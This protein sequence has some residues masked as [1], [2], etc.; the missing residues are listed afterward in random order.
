MP[1]TTTSPNASMPMVLLSE[2]SAPN[3]TSTMATI[4]VSSLTATI[5]S[6][7]ATCMALPSTK[8]SPKTLVPKPTGCWLTTKAVSA[9]LSIT[10]AASS[11]SSPTTATAI[12]ST[13]PTPASPFAS[14]TPAA[15]GMA[16]PDSIT[17]VRDITM[18]ES[19]GS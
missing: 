4:S 11:T 2:E 3:A 18:P 17:T 9:K 1:S 7:N 12:S 16:K 10:P 8:A 19:A 15:S 5:V 13:K 6:N 14:A